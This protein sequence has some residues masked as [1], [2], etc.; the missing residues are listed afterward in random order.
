VLPSKEAKIFEASKNQI[1]QAS[2]QS[3]YQDID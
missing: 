2:I 3:L 1:L